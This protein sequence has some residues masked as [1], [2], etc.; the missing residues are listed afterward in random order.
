MRDKRKR[1]AEILAGVTRRLYQSLVT[2]AYNHDVDSFLNLKYVSFMSSISP[3]DL[4][5]SKKKICI[6]NSIQVI[7]IS[8]IIRNLI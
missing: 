2:P 8:V 7:F 4:L 1:F 5:L 6:I 3:K